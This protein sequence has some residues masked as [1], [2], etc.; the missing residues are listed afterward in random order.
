MLEQ[1]DPRPGERVGRW[2]C[3]PA[4][5]AVM[6]FGCAPA[7]V[8]PTRAEGTRSNLSPHLLGSA[9][10]CRW[11]PGSSRKWMA[12]HALLALVCTAAIDGGAAGPRGGG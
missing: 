3:V 1:R 4:S 12:R 9:D 2:Q 10:A 5:V 8:P 11:R 7:V 6:R